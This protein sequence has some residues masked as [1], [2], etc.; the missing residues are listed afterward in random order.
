MGRLI[1]IVRK[2]FQTHACVLVTTGLPVSFSFFSPHFAEIIVAGDVGE[3]SFKG[4][5]RPQQVY[6]IQRLRA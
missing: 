1:P 4:F 3:L 2:A 6:N 5:Q